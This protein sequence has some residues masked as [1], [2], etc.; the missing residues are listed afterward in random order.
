MFYWPR[1]TVFRK[2]LILTLALFISMPRSWGASIEIDFTTI[3]YHLMFGRNNPKK[4]RNGLDKYG[5]FASNPGLGVGYDFRR[6]S[7]DGG[8][9]GVARILFFHECDDD[10]AFFGG[11]GGKYRFLLRKHLSI[12]LQGMIGAYVIQRVL[13]KNK[14]KSNYKYRFGYDYILH[15]APLIVFGVNYHFDSGSTLAFHSAF[16]PDG[17]FLFTFQGSLPIAKS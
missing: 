10:L 3:S 4:L 5:V 2:A 9:H 14:D 15:P 11:G 7:T 8:L 1:K 17:V 6:K 13:C 12:D 16:R